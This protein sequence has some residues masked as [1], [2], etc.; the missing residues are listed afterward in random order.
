MPAVMKPTLLILAAGIGSRYGGLKQ[1]DSL[2]P[3][4][5]TIMDYSINDAIDAGFGKVVVVIR[6]E[7]KKDFEEKIVSR[8]K[9]KVKIEFAYQ[10]VNPKFDGANVVK[11]EKPWGPIH[12][13]LSV[14]ENINEPFA[15]INADDF[16][17]VNSFKETADFLLQGCSADHYALVGYILSHTLS[18]HGS[19][20]RGVCETSGDNI[21]TGIREFKEVKKKDTK[22]TGLHNGKIKTLDP[23]SFVSMNFWGFHPFFFAHAQ[24]IFMEFVEKSANNPKA[25][26]TLPDVIGPLIKTGK[27]KV[28]VLPCSENWF[29]VTYLED[30][31]SVIEKLKHLDKT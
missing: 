29:G 15:V 17:G 8:W 7:F 4:G 6:K 27:I 13:V 20:S 16:Y 11:R 10:E 18:E 22:I 5:E 31:E 14:K 21:L 23:N 9:G 25:E 28:S 1:L 26:M 12:A 2:G 30:R 19:V 24:K 3:N